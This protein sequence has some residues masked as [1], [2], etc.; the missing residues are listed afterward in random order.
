M[1]I[2]P[3]FEK[4]EW[5]AKKGDPEKVFYLPVIL[6]EFGP[7]I[8]RFVR[9][10]YRS[11]IR[12]KVHA[13]KKGHESLFPN[14][15]HFFYDWDDSIEVNERKKKKLGSF[16]GMGNRKWVHENFFISQ[17][18]KILKKYPK[19]QNYT[20]VYPFVKYTD[21]SHPNHF[22]HFNIVETR[23]SNISADVIITPRFKKKYNKPLILYQRICDILKNYGFSVGVVGTKEMS[24]NDLNFD[25]ASWDYHSTMYDLNP[26]IELIR[27]AKFVV[28]TNCGM[29]HLA[30][31]MKKNIIFL[32]D[33]AGYGWYINKQVHPNTY[34]DI[35]DRKSLSIT[36]NGFKEKTLKNAINKYINFQK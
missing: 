31:L 26:D 29:L 2:D 11:D 20:F 10:V 9:D 32:R 23:S 13:V 1:A 24:Y 30:I 14:I 36:E 17:L 33:R 6:N 5:I 28:A 25:V 8:C 16:R 7:Y 12:Q 22:V 35:L 15:N 19:Y 27:K 4:E 34:F 3:I 21:P 18:K